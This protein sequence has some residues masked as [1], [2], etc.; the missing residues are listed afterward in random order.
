MRVLLIEP[1]EL[2]ARV[3]LALLHRAGIKTTRIANPKEAPSKLKETEYDCTLLSIEH[4][5]GALE[6]NLQILQTVRS[7]TSVILISDS[8]DLHFFLEVLQLPID[9]YWIKGDFDETM[10]LRSVLLASEHQRRLNELRQRV[11]LL[12]KLVERTTGICSKLV[13]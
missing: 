9:D 7:I 8:D 11:S 5:S 10:I 2:D 3:T 12:E 4:D 1:C 13:D 6:E